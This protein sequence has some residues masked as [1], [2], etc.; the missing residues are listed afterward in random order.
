MTSASAVT[1]TVGAVL[2]TGQRVDIIQDGTGQVTISGSGITLV[3]AGTS[4]YRTRGQY[5]AV[6]IVCLDSASGAYRVIGDMVL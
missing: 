3:G 6:T 1:V 5:S 4:P 2:S